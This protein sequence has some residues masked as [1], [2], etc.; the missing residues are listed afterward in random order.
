[1]EIVKVTVSENP[2]EPTYVESVNIVA[3]DNVDEIEIRK[4]TTFDGPELIVE[5]DDVSYCVF[6]V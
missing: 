1:M 6:D 4:V 2:E 3:L 5:R